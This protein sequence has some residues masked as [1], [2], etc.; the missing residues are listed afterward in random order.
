ME[1]DDEVLPL[2]V[3]QEGEREIVQ[4]LEAVKSAGPDMERLET[5]RRELFAQGNAYVQA[6]LRRAQSGNDAAAPGKTQD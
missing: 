2:D 5:L 1:L 3:R 6:V 4:F